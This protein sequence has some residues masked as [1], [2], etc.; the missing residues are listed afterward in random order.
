MNIDK[1]PVND[2]Q[3]DDDNF[4]LQNDVYS[5]YYIYILLYIYWYL[6]THST[7]GRKKINQSL[8]KES[9]VLHFIFIIFASS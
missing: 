2:R 1:I 6:D 8:G 5:D 3:T 7:K 4:S 9:N